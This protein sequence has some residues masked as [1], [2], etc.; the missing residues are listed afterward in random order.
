MIDLL[1]LTQW[2]S[3]AFPVGAFAY[4][5]GL[6]TAIDRG[7]VGNAESLRAWLAQT[8]RRGAG[9]VDAVLLARALASEDMAQ[10]ARALAGC[11]ERWEETVAQGAAFAATLRAMG[12]DARDAALP[13]VVGEAARGLAVAPAQVAALYLQGYAGNLATIAVR[14]VPLGQSDGQGVLAA[15]APD[16]AATAEWAAGAGIEDIATTAF[17]ADLCAM[18]HATQEV[19]I[20][21]T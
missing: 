18:A 16:I 1:R 12:H 3:P 11:A 2:L 5:S 13:V 15:L 20:Y 21:R 6:E 8:V 19:R 17:T 10:T 14:H 7:L 4:S 9:A